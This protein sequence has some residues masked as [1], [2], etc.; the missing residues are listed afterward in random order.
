MSFF[1][2]QHKL[3]TGVYTLSVLD[4]TD[5]KYGGRTRR[6]TLVCYDHLQVWNYPTKT[7]I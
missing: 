6:N 1:L 4:I 2:F 5:Q 7:G 3:S